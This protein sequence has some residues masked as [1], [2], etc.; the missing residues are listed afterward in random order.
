MAVKVTE[1]M[2]VLV[3]VVMVVWISEVIVMVRLVFR[4]ESC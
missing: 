1:M 3:V 2:V 4:N